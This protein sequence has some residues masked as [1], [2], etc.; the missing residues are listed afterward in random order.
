MCVKGVS[1]GQ[2]CLAGIWAFKHA[3]LDR[4]PTQNF[5]LGSLDQ[6]DYR[7]PRPTVR[8]LGQSP[9]AIIVLAGGP[10]GRRGGM[11]VSESGSDDMRHRWTQS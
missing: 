2:N 8:V 5:E 1:W 4:Q 7:C 10:E 9:H 11:R 6:A 3:G